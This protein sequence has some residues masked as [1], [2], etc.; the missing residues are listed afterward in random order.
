VTLFLNVIKSAAGAA[1][2]HVAI[3]RGVDL[4]NERRLM[5]IMKD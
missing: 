5:D 3:D 4:N 2:I 1:I